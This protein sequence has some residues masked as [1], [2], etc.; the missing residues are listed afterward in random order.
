MGKKKDKGFS[1]LDYYLKS[2]KLGKAMERYNVEG[3]HYGHPDGRSGKPNRTREDVDRDLAAAAMNDYDTRR[4]L[5]AAAM[6]GDKKAK[7]YAKNGFEDA[8][9]VVGAN[10]M[11]RKWHKKEGNGGDFSSASD[12]AGLTHAMVQRDRDAQTASYDEKYA[13]TKDLNALKEEMEAK[14]TDKIDDT[15]ITPSDRLAGVQERLASAA[16]NE[17][18]SLF[19]KENAEP[20]TADDQKDAARSFLDDYKFDVREGAGIRLDVKAGVKNAAEE[21][22]K[23]QGKDIYGR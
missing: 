19:S 4:S 17:P 8:S 16:G 15:P 2:G 3:V 18:P 23:N 6:S 20:A 21:V 7:K 1:H 13:S 22:R 12:F 5:E 11:F 9:D 10:N 14:A